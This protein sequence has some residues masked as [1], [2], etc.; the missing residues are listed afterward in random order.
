MR[1]GPSGPCC[2][3]LSVSHIQCLDALLQQL[4]ASLW[5]SALRNGTEDDTAAGHS[6]Q[7]SSLLAHMCHTVALILSHNSRESLRH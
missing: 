2:V 1:D 4:R 6:L 7:T 3:Q 5:V